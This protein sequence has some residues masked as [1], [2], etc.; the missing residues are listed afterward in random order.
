MTYSSRGRKNTRKPAEDSRELDW[1]KLIETALTVPGSV[2]NTYNRFYEYSFLNQMLLLM[3]GVQEPVATYNRWLELGRQVKRGSKAY[4]IIRPITVKRTVVE[5]GEE[6]VKPFSRFKMVKCLFTVSQTE[7]EDLPPAQP[8]GW[9]LSV[10]EKA[11]DIEQVQYA[12]T[13]GNTQGYSVERKYAVNPVAVDPMHTAFHEL[14]HIVLGHTTREKLG[15]YIHHR[16]LFEFQAEAVAYLVMHELG[17]LD[18]HAA[19][20]SRGYIQG[21][22]S[23]SERPSDTAIQAV[24]KA[25]DTI[26]KAGRAT[27][28]AAAD[29]P[30]LVGGGVS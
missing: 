1:A 14:A 8:R 17:R 16:G 23:G 13:D 2:G 24:F 3:Q 5:D 25:T 15:E 20:H 18:E 7:G 6:V 22:L 4:E 26:L 30:V 27:T 29:E 11:L 10:A 9:D 28:P 21:W 12:S 19:S